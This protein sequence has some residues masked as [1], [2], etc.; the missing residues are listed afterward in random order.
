MWF[1]PTRWPSAFVEVANAGTMPLSVFVRS[2]ADCPHTAT[3][4]CGS[5]PRAGQLA[6]IQN[7][8]V[9]WHLRRLQSL[10]SLPGCCWLIFYLFFFFLPLF[11]F[12]FLPGSECGVRGRA[13]R[14]EVGVERER[15]KT[16]THTQRSV[17]VAVH[18]ILF[19][20]NWKRMCT[21]IKVEITW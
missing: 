9:G 20:V 3:G 15:E 11:F 17:S 18:G 19:S 1:F 7:L 8:G 6:G 16:S 14:L 21:K 12:F 5:P 10:S 2:Q 4:H 13:K